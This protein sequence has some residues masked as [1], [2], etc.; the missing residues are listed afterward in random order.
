MS[1]DTYNP[2]IL[3]WPRVRFFDHSY[4]C[5][6]Y[7][8]PDA[9][10]TLNSVATLEAGKTFSVALDGTATHEGGSCQF[11]VSYDQ[12]KTF[13]VI[14]SIIGGCP[15]GLHFNVPIPANLPAQKKATFA[16]TWQNLV[17]NREE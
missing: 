13:A 4:P 16:W 12:G 11:S 15:I 10:S 2:K 9:Y 8:T 6:G 14:A 7:N 1:S 3:I 5:K 17:G